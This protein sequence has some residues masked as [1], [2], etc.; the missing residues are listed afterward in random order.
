MAN[1]DGECCRDPTFTSTLNIHHCPF[2]ISAVIRFSLVPA[3]IL[4][5]AASA[6][7]PAAELSTIVIP[8][9]SSLAPLLPQ[10]EAQ[11][12]KRIEKLDAYELDP[13][14]QFGIKY[15]VV[16]DPVALT[17]IGSGIHS[18]TTLHYALEGCKRTQKPFTNDI[19][20]WPC[21]SCGF[22]EPMR[23][24]YL[25]L[26]TH[27]E[28]DAN[29]RLR[30]TTRAMPVEFSNHRCEVTAA[31]ID[32]TEWKLAPLMNAQ[33]QRVA[34]TIDANTP[35]L[36]SIRPSAQQ[37]W[38]A[39]QSPVQVAPRTWLVFEPADVGLAPITGSGL[40]VTTA[41]SLRA[42]T[43]IVVGERP[44]LA[45]APLPA[46]HAA[47]PAPAGLRVPFDVE[48][49]YAEANRLLTENFGHRQY[50]GVTVDTIG[51]APAAAGRVSI[52]LNIDY[53]ASALRKYKGL[54]YLEATPRF[55]AAS[56]MVVLDGL[57]YTLDPRRKNPFVRIADRL[58]HDTL[59]ARLAQSA[60]WSLAPQLTAMRNEITRALTRPL[61][62]G[63]TMRGRIDAIEPNGVM[64]DPN[65]LTIHALATGS[66]DVAM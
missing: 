33:L 38:T 52:T 65:A 17:V 43:R 1:V 30:S 20:M 59:R 47:Q 26:N 57:D 51:I 53:R 2:N 27:L 8:I 60:R 19:V 34:K 58:A 29:W 15:R 28:W 24:A 64:I 21:V 18:T 50:D 11:V 32:I 45:A 46:L 4:A 56:R 14:G 13:Q 12:P 10:I 55:D 36:T 25:S 66:A 63:V 6:Q 42:R 5:A 49:P 39:L 9:R 3:L 7:Q 23:D 54:V 62:A 40:I 35:K 16:R 37:V 41:L 44:V 48:L 31:S 22:G 61:A